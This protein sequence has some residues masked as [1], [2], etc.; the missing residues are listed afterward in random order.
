MRP[1][2]QMIIGRQGGGWQAFT[3]GGKI[4]KQKYGRHPDPQHQ[5]NFVES[6]KSRK[7]P[8]ADIEIVHRSAAMVHLANIAHRVG[9]QK[10]Q[11]DQE[12]ERFI[13]HKEANK[14]VKRDYRKG[15][16]ISETV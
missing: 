3:G 15:Y 2:E 14:L 10:L 1:K 9:N 12:K 13:N 8:N 7:R 16:Q 4:V 6:V 5:Q 11:F